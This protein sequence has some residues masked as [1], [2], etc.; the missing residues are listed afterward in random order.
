MPIAHESLKLRECCKISK[1]GNDFVGV[2]IDTNKPKIYFPM[3]YELPKDDD[4]LRQDV[5]NLIKIL[6]KFT[7]ES[8]GYIFV[9][10]LFAS[11]KTV[12]FPFQSY[13]DI[14]KYYLKNNASYYIETE[15]SYKTSRHG[16][17]DWARTIKQITP[18]IQGN[19][20]IYLDT[21]VR[22]STPNANMM[23]TLIN[24]YCVYESFKRIGWLYLDYLPEKAYAPADKNTMIAILKYKMGNTNNDLNKRLFNSMIAML[25]FKGSCNTDKEICIGTNKFEN[26]WEKLIDSAF[27]NSKKRAYVPRGQ[28]GIRG[29]KSIKCSEL[30]P[31]TIMHYED[32][33]YVLDAKY[34][35]YGIQ[36]DIA[37]LPQTA[38]INKQITYGQSVSKKDPKNRKVYNAYLMPFNSSKN[39]F[40]N[41][42]EP[43]L[44]VIEATGDWI[45]APETHERI[46]G[47]ILDTRY[48]MKNYRGNR[49]KN[50]K[51]LS[52]TI[53]KRFKDIK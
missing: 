40:G 17:I 25:E 5:R 21:I 29:G 6:S 19:S 24:K 33:Y 53:E 16:K 23:I 11:Q 26:V 32:K 35:T 39:N 13:V 4:E 42:K 28:W 7:D 22:N 15:T 47:I 51:L 44:N 41:T 34:Y 46:Q 1:S 10:N 3:G 20:L 36:R 48:L 37:N 43:M 52:K 30:L 49:L 2:K 14:I 18:I 12:N 50:M 38:D 31:D 45:D 8:D 27:G 9:D